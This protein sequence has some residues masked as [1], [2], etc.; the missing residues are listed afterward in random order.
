MNMDRVFLTD[1][2][3]PIESFSWGAFVI[4]GQEHSGSGSERV[5]KGK[6][7]R[8]IGENVTRWKERK[9]HEIR[10]SMIT[11]VY[12]ED[13]D[14]LVIGAGV[15]SGLDVPGKVKKDIAAHGIDE[16]IVE[17]TPEACRI[18]NRLYREGR[19]VAL[20]AHGTC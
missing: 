7:I 6:D 3:G 10:K 1:A 17:P 9:G 8:M 14:V 4:R 15:E 18:Y 13:V 19:K 12:D 11:G 16:L 20:L 2:Q 5:G